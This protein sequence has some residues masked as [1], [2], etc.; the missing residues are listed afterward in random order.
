MLAPVETGGTALVLHEIW[1]DIQQAGIFVAMARRDGLL[2]SVTINAIGPD[3]CRVK[4][5]FAS[6]YWDDRIRPRIEETLGPKVR[7]VQSP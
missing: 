3:R 2:L 4:V 5:Y 1:P 6:A 7:P